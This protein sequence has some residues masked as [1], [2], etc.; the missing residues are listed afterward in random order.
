M[1][2][3]ILITCLCIL[4]LS[5]CGSSGKD[6]KAIKECQETEY[7][8]ITKEQNEMLPNTVEHEGLSV[9]LGRNVKTGKTIIF[10]NETEYDGLYDFEFI[11]RDP[12]NFTKYAVFHKVSDVE[13]KSG[14]KWEYDLPSNVVGKYITVNEDRDG[15]D[16]NLTLEVV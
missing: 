4:L 5:G 11:V 3:G 7:A 13:I 14:Q 16:P 15:G 2:K 6:A 10:K 12:E 1:K 8:C 9:D